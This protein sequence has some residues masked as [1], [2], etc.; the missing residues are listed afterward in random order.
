MNNQSSNFQHEFSLEENFIP[1]T[2]KKIYTSPIQS[3][4]NSDSNNI[5]DSESLSET[6][7]IS[8]S[9]D[10]KKTFTKKTFH[11]YLTNIFT[12]ITK[13]TSKLLNVCFNKSDEDEEDVEDED[14]ED[15]DEDE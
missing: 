12:S 15:E 14:E 5:S 4:L 9:N 7:S 3:T 11:E 8:E 6:E 2:E 13:D 10:N 1:I